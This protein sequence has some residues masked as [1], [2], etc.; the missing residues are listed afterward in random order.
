MARRAGMLPL[1]V[2]KVRE[3]SQVD[4]LAENRE[5]CADTGRFFAGVLSYKATPE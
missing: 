2:E 5:V 4:L 1:T 3:S